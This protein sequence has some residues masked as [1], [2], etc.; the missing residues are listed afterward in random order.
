MDLSDKLLSFHDKLAQFFEKYLRI[1]LATIVVFLVIGLSWI[2]FTYYKSKKEKTAS[3]KLMEVVKS[4]NIIQALQ[5][6]K[7]KYKGTQAA[8]QASLLLLDY[9]YNQKNYQEM[10][11]LIDELQKE[12]PR[13]IKGVI[14]YGKAKTFEIQGDLSKALELYKEVSKEQ[15]ELNFLTY[16]DI[17]RV[18]EKLGKFDLAREYY[19]KYLKE[20]NIKNSG[21]VEY[22]LSQLGKK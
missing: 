1:I 3:L 6:V 7:E 2:G 10:Q 9:Y 11:K 15:P 8:L 18:A 22:K 13:K 4:P 17:A 20:S 19:Q 5:E 16:L 14:L 12:Y 21:Y